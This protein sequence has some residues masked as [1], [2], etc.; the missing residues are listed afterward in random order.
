MSVAVSAAIMFNLVCSGYADKLSGVGPGRAAFE[1]TIILDL[2]HKQWCLY[3]KGRTCEY[4]AHIKHV[5][6]YFIVLEKQNDRFNGKDNKRYR[7][8]NRVNGTYGFKQQNA[9]F[10]AFTGAGCVQQPF[11]GFPK[12]VF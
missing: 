11:S 9:A 7:F 6:P 12:P 4:V 1:A 5:S 2:K 3:E 10:S 8:I